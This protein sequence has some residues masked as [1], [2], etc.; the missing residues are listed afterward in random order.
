MRLRDT[1][2]WAM[3]IAVAFLVLWCA[4]VGVAYAAP[5]GEAEP[6]PAAAQAASP[7][8]HGIGVAGWCIVGAG[9][10][11]FLAAVLLNSLEHRRRKVHR[12]GGYGRLRRRGLSGGTGVYRYRQTAVRRYYR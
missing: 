2:L 3:V 11:A 1:R 8:E 7:A 4:S 6:T 12:S 9:G 10:V 5:A